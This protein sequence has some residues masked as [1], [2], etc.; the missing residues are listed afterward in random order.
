MTNE[1]FHD[2]LY[3][4]RCRREE[5][6]RKLREAELQVT[7]AVAALEVFAASCRDGDDR[8]Y[9]TEKAASIRDRASCVVQVERSFRALQDANTD[10]MRDTAKD[11]AIRDSELA[12]W[13]VRFPQYKFRPQD[14][15][16]ALA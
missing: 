5:A 11:I 8:K 16:V 14:N 13:R 15:C 7:I 2:A 3:R 10:L 6:E 4:E 9:A 1:D 12:A